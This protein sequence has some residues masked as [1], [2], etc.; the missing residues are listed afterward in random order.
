MA[1]F[2][3]LAWQR[4]W[5]CDDG[6]IVLRT[7][8]NL[9]HGDGPV[10]NAGE[11][12]EANTSTLWTYVLALGG[13]QPWLRLEWVSVVVGLVS[14]VGGLF[15]G[16]DGARRLFPGR[17]V[18]P[19]GGLVVLALPPFW[20]YA[21][22]GLETGLVTLWLALVWW[23]LVRH[24]TGGPVRVWPTVL[25]IGLGPLVRPEFALVSAIAFA[26]LIA[27]VRPGWRRAL[28]LLVLAGVLPVAYQVF[29][30]GYY[31]LIT[32]N[33]ALAK[34]ATQARWDR[35]W[36]YLVDFFG[37]Y[38]LLVPV[39]LLLAAAV[40][41]LR[42]LERKTLVVALTP[43]VAGILLGLYVTRVGGD[44]MHARMLLP[45]LT[46]LLLPIM[47]VPLT[48]WT[49]P[50][51]L[52][53]VAWTV[54]SAVGL[55]PASAEQHKIG[56]YGISDARVFW[57]DSTHNEHPI[58]AE[59]AGL[60]PGYLPELAAARAKVTGPAVAV[61]VNGTWVLYPA[62]HDVVSSPGALG[63]PGMLLPR[64]ETVIDDLGLAGPLAAHSLP[65]TGRPA[66]HQKLLSV[67]WVIADAGVG[68]PEQLSAAGNELVWSKEILAARIALARPEIR[69][70]L[71]SVRAPLTFG[72]FWDNLVHSV[73]RSRLR[74]NP[75][76]LDAQF[77]G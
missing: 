5:V 14:A 31:G 39:A 38:W 56:A 13:L 21:T 8:E 10:F 67:A 26:A 30:M 40:L 41:V 71:D 52:A 24:A 75:H 35:G 16:L 33:T 7:V 62:T 57:V 28:G 37:S 69:E 49:T 51:V 23:Q 3:F 45:V 36:F 19:A 65:I 58:T 1:I 29:R 54:T 43:V 55:R 32:P 48:R 9:L 59:D 74:F 66:G 76:P 18:V 17:R 77:G 50:L 64:D 6:L 44:Y 53:V 27:V 34:E 22:S 15:F 11:R 72:R 68:T 4:R 63:F 47:V 70:M 73:G 2:A 12:V 25:L 60:I 46:C 61:S 20:D 42:S